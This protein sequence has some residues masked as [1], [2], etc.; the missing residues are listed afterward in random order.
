MTFNDRPRHLSPHIRERL[1]T[2]CKRDIHSLKDIIVLGNHDTLASRGYFV[3]Y[4]FLWDD[5]VSGPRM[6]GVDGKWNCLG[7][8][9]EKCSMISNRVCINTH[10]PQ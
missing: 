2:N 6:L 9:P 1:N 10:Y 3:T 4:P 8:T 7:L 5:S